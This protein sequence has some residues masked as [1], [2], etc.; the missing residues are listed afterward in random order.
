MNT[1][2]TV[3]QQAVGHMLGGA[4]CGHMHKQG[5]HAQ[6]EAAAGNS[7]HAGA[8]ANSPSTGAAPNSPHKGAD[9]TSPQ[10][11]MGGD[12]RRCIQ[13][14]QHAAMVKQQHRA[15]VR[16]RHSEHSLQQS[17]RAGS[18]TPDH[19]AAAE[20]SKPEE[21]HGGQSPSGWDRV[22]RVVW[23]SAVP[24]KPPKDSVT[25]ALESTSLP[26]EGNPDTRELKH[27]D[28]SS[29]SMSKN[30][31]GPL[32]YIYS[33]GGKM[34]AVLALLGSK[35]KGRQGESTA[36]SAETEAAADHG[37]SSPCEITSPGAEN[38]SG[39]DP[40]SKFGASQPEQA[41]GSTEVFC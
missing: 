22:R 6:Q 8:T 15:E 34:A 14:E 3:P 7:P 30:T 20:H 36:R 29:G 4:G 32:Q 11:G 37:D 12:H 13:E 9:G 41:A 26:P 21:Q 17:E 2:H 39:D 40:I 38:H 35:A 23:G 24:A 18:P 19:T 28:S 10:T 16:K 25:A 5:P 31:T 33:R 1:L 27:S